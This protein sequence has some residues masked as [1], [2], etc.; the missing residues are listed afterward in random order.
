MSKDNVLA[1]A[2]K[3]NARNILWLKGQDTDER[4][5][6]FVYFDTYRRG[7][8]ISFLH[9]SHRRPE[10]VSRE[11][12][13]LNAPLPNMLTYE[14]A[15]LLSVQRAEQNGWMLDSVEVPM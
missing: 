5:V 13:P 9:Y 6:H 4:A 2:R 15:L 8:T 10:F 14:E 12:Q 11:P 1:W 3:L 7:W